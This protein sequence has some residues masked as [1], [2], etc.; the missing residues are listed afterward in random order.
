MEILEKEMAK[1]SEQFL[2]FSNFMSHLDAA[3]K[4]T[5][6]PKIISKLYKKGKRKPKNP[7]KI[8]IEDLNAI[9]GLPPSSSSCSQ[10]VVGGQGSTLPVAIDSVGLSEDTKK[11][12]IFTSRS[13][14]LSGLLEADSK[15]QGSD[16]LD[17]DGKKFTGPAEERFSDI[18]HDAITRLWY[19]K[20]FIKEGELTTHDVYEGISEYI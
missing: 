12:P 17:Q 6:T 13:R 15:T 5:I 4:S 1:I 7:W 8:K 20:N 19:P 2:S 9:S 16:G 3:A 10:D 11:A 18:L 14:R